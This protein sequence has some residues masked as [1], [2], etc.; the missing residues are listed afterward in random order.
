MKKHVQI[1]LIIEDGKVIDM[2]AITNSVNRVEYVQE[3]EENPMKKIE[4]LQA[5]HDI[6]DEHMK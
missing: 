3:W 2:E 1:N 5:L 6:V 4:V